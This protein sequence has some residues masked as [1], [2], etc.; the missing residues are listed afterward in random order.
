M[1]CAYGNISYGGS[2]SAYINTKITPSTFLLNGSDF[3]SCSGIAVEYT[4]SKINS[5][6]YGAGTLVVPSS[7]FDSWK[8]INSTISIVT[9]ND[10]IPTSATSNSVFF[11][12][13][14]GLK[15]TAL[16]AK[17][18]LK[19]KP[20]SNVLNN[21]QGSFVRRYTDGVRV[22]S[23]MQTSFAGGT[24][25]TTNESGSAKI[26]STGTGAYVKQSSTIYSS[27]PTISSLDAQILSATSNF[28]QARC[29]GCTFLMYAGL[30]TGYQLTIHCPITFYL[31]DYF[32]TG[33]YFALIPTKIYYYNQ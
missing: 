9:K 15:N 20:N 18:E 14:T 32:S 33:L 23:L 17:S 29:Y 2:N 25:N 24:R 27:Y 1:P 21:I 13:I 3:E 4:L 30:S 12:Q 5:I 11:K 6:Y 16:F 26:L 7:L 31:A 28:D 10:D 19:A 22:D 8:N